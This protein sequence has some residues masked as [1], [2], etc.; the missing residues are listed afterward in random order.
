M[1]YRVLRRGRK[2]EAS[3]TTCPCTRLCTCLAVSL[4]S[5]LFE[6]VDPTAG[7]AVQV[8]HTRPHCSQQS[9][10]VKWMRMEDEEEDARRSAV[11][12][13]CMYVLIEICFEICSSTT[14]E[15]RCFRVSP[16]LLQAPTENPPLAAPTE[17]GQI[18]R[19]RLIEVVPAR[20]DVLAA[21]GNRG[22]NGEG[23]VETRGHVGFW[24]YP[25]TR[26]YYHGGSVRVRGH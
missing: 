12:H 10:C 9:I 24:Y 5:A 26:C 6:L 15:Y 22:K 23:S 2:S 13:V 8:D 16:C 20:S 17:R 25:V 14:A 7:I 1:G 4:A 3:C 19:R 18:G 21:R 11:R